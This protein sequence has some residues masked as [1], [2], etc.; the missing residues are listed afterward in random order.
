[1]S[2]REAK[3]PEDITC[4]SN[5][6]PWTLI[7]DDDFAAY[8]LGLFTTQS[9]VFNVGYHYYTARNKKEYIG[10]ADGWLSLRHTGQQC[11]NLGLYYF[12]IFV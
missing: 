1:M 5:A 8:V 6:T 3:R 7:L 9:N 2:S 10:A 4:L 11:N 12:I